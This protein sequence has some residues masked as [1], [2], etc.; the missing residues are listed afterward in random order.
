MLKNYFKIALRQLLKNKFQ[1]LLLVGGMAVG[2][3]ACLLLLQYVSF[4]LSYDDFHSKRDQLYRVVN[5]RIQNGQTVQK[6]TITYPTIGPAMY[7]DFPEVVNYSRLRPAGDVAIRYKDKV[8]AQSGMFW[9]DEHFLELFDFPMLASSGIDMLQETNQIVISREVADQYFPAARNNYQAVLGK[10]VELNNDPDPYTIVGVSENVPT[11]S[12]LQ[13]N[14]LVSYATHIRYQ[15]E[16]ADNSWTWSDFWHFVELDPEADLAALE[17][18]LP[19]FSE[20]YFRG[21]EVSGSEEVFTLQPL[22]DAHLYSSGLEYEIGDTSNGSAVWSLLIIAFFI[23]IIAWI[24]YLNLS[25]VRAIERAKE[26]GVRKVV[27]AKRS[28]LMVQFFTE[29]LLVNVIALVLAW[30]GAILLR[31]WFAGN[32]DLES[33]VLRFTSGSTIFLPITLVG[34][35]LA[36]LLISGAYPAWL[37]SS[38]HVSSILKGTFQRGF[39][40]GKLRK[41]LVVFQFTASIALIT[42][43]WLVSRQISFMNRQEL[44]VNIEQVMTIEPPG[45][46]QWDSTFITRMD[47][48]KDKLRNNPKI[49]EAATSNR[50]LGDDW[51]GRVFNIQVD[52]SAQQETQFTS[53]FIMTDHDYADTYEMQPLAGRFFRP[54]DH[55]ANFQD[56]ENIVLTEEAVE[57]FG[58]GTPDEAVGQRLNFWNQDWTVVG[59]LPD[60]HSMS[61]HHPIEPLIFVPAYG[62]G[63]KLSLRVDTEDLEATIG[64]IRTTFDDFFPGNFFDYAFVNETFNRLY[65]SDR[66][67]GRILGFFTLVAVLIACLGL[68]GLASYMTF[69]RTKEIGVRKI[70]GASTTGL[71]MLL[72]K[73]FLKLVLI[74]LLI[75]TPIAWYFLDQWLTEFPYRVDLEWWM[76]LAAGAVAGLVAFLA[77][78]LQSLQAAMANPVESL[79]SE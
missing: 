79:R 7:A 45:L 48:F 71:L 38:P 53:S 20:R 69:L 3:T 31:P 18:K 77:V 74:A 22:K 62:T 33:A 68:F 39:G 13:F 56:L 63:N 14:V 47:A 9:V 37:L 28:T 57:K 2:M 21:A 70:L 42:G 24:N 10:E 16:G 1:T 46:T 43:T 32:F 54:G 30:Q 59:V 66:R 23:L 72:S 73:D 67:F 51:H 4:E 25:S 44:G 8:A 75:A 40:G 19:A 5:E 64:Y 35:I 55:H 36:G 26:V 60:Y 78:G 65:E 58:L 49:K 27:G 12:F 29:A 6:G 41:A 50:T 52:N 34:L 15:G 76:F 17:A 11:N 61:L